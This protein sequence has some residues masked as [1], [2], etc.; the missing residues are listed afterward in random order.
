ML[1]LVLN[2]FGVGNIFGEGSVH[3]GH[4]GV[5]RDFVTRAG[6]EGQARE[7]GISFLTQPLFSFNF[8]RI[9]GVKYGKN[10]SP[11]D[12]NCKARG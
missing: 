11:S 2:K 3:R 1:G 4:G 5:H 10:R 8:F 6:M 12:G 9:L 7:L